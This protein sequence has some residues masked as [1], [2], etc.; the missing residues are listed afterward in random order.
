MT[1]GGGRGSEEANGPDHPAVPLELARV[2]RTGRSEAL[3]SAGRPTGALCKYLVI[4]E[5]EGVRERE[6]DQELASAS[7]T[8]SNRERRR[9]IERG[10]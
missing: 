1:G 3:C 5:R 6:R 9:D 8:A 10:R 2:H 7:E 4:R